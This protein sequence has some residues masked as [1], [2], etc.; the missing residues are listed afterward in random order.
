L[1]LNGVREPTSPVIA[2]PDIHIFM[3]LQEVLNVIAAISDGSS[4]ILPK[5]LE[6]VRLISVFIPR[7]WVIGS[8]NGPSLKNTAQE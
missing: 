4:Y 6:F 2:P 1:K 5:R 3:V 8:S 7:I